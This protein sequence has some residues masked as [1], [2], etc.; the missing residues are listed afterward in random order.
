MTRF[1]TDSP[2]ATQQFAHA[3]AGLVGPGDLVLLIGEMGAGKTAFAQGF[4]VGLG[5]A[6]QVT[7]PTFTLVRHY[8][9]RLPMHHIDV[10]RLDTMAEV[11]DLGLGELIDSDGVTLIEWGDAIRAALPVDRLEITL[12]FGD[13]IDERR[14]EVDAFGTWAPRQR[15]LLGALG[16]WAC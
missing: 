7:S 12:E 16:G 4:A 3:L 10:Y 5:V 13:E 6:E 1:R 9:G 11:S 8:E 2:S 15:Q 14:I